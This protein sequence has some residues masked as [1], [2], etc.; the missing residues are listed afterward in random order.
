[1][2]TDVCQSGDS[3]GSDRAWL[4]V[5]QSYDHY[6]RVLLPSTRKQT[7]VEVDEVIWPD[8]DIARYYPILCQL[9]RKVI[10]R[11]AVL[12]P[13]YKYLEY[14]YRDLAQVL[15]PEPVDSCY[16][17]AITKFNTN[18]WPIQGG[19]AWA[20]AAFWTEISK[21]RL[22]VYSLEYQK[23]GLVYQ[24]PDG[25]YRFQR[26]GMVPKPRGLYTGIGTRDVAQDKAIEI[27]SAIY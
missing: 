2:D 8:I 16:A 27:I 22:F 24:D 9:A 25:I 1:M 20:T 19:T 26:L 3:E 5:A 18:Q 13:A 21:D 4:Q 17:I 23:W 11:P 15:W 7:T 10:R 12:G 6:T 14:Q